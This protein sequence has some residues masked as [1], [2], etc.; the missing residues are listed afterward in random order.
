M[1][2]PLQMIFNQ[3]NIINTGTKFKFQTVP[4]DPHDAFRGKYITL[5]V[6]EEKLR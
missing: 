2:V 1:F 6:K 4:L 5:F 3:E